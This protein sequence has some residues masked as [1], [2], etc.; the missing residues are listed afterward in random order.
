MRKMET[1]VYLAEH[2]AGHLR[3]DDERVIFQIK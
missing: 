2:K 1:D 3:A